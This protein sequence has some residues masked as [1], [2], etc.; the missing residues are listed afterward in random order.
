MLNICYN[1]HD[2]FEFCYRL[3]NRSERAAVVWRRK[4]FPL[5]FRFSSTYFF[6][7]QPIYFILTN[8]VA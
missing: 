8:I 6:I 3:V 7:S 2:M 4:Q 1:F 5:K